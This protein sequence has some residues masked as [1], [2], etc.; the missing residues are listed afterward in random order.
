MNR[1]QKLCVGVVGTAVFAW[2]LSLDGV[3]QAVACSCCHRR[4]ADRAG[5]GEAVSGA[6]IGSGGVGLHPGKT[7]TPE[8]R[9]KLT[10]YSES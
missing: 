9:P 1:E 8:S 3:C 7:P 5:S 2:R 10:F 6:N 4:N